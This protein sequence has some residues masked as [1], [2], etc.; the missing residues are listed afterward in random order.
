[1]PTDKSN[2][3]FFFRV[4]SKYLFSNF[5]INKNFVW[6]KIFGK[7]PFYLVFAFTRRN[8]VRVTF[9]VQ[10]WISGTKNNFLMPCMANSRMTDFSIFF[11]IEVQNY[12]VR[13][14]EKKNFHQNFDF[15]P[16]MH[17]FCHCWMKSGKMPWNE[18]GCLL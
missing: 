16:K 7:R 8:G 2:C 18:Y 1:M 14:V 15:W 17:L 10:K 12:W 5:F 6:M 4:L 9:W 11:N 3:K 13:I